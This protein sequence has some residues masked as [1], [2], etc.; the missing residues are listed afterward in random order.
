MPNQP[1]TPSFTISPAMVNRIAAI[2]ERVGGIQA[3]ALAASPQLRKRNRIKTI[4]GTLAIEGNSLSEQQVTAIMDGK[5]VLG[6]VREVAEVAGA[7]KAYEAAPDLRPDKIDDLLRAHALMLD[8][9]LNK[10][11]HFRQV[12]VGIRKGSTASHVAPPAN[13][14]PGMMADLCVWLKRTD[15]HPLI[16]SSV[17][18]YEFEFIHPFIDGNGRMGRLWQTLI[19]AQ[20]QPLFLSLPIES[21]IK[22]HQQEYYQVLE[23]SDKQADSSP[24]IHFMLSIILETL[25]QITANEQITRS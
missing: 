24:F 21:L 4:T 20:W 10:A 13:R 8:G 25:I 23:Q 9:I 16:A 5:P 18:H 11:G 7:I 19:L 22:E 6:S 2:A 15:E 14:V 1:R 3:T 17:F 12:A